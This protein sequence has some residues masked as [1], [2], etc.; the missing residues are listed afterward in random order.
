VRLRKRSPD[1]GDGKEPTAPTGEATSR[2]QEQVIACATREEAER[3]AARQQAL[4]TDD[5]IWIYV[6]IDGQWT[7][8]RTPRDIA[9]VERKGRWE[10][11]AD[12][13]FDMFLGGGA[14][15]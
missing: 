9:A 13:V 1:D 12:V 3:E 15:T 2:F 4:D 8:K 7:A 11:A 6:C 5:A 14:G 10:V